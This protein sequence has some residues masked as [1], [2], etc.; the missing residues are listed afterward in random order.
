MYRRVV[1][2]LVT[3]YFATSVSAHSLGG[4]DDI[5]VLAGSLDGATL[6][7]VETA[8]RAVTMR[9]TTVDVEGHEIGSG[10]VV[11]LLPSET[12]KLRLRDH[13]ASEALGSRRIQ[14][15]VLGGEGRVDVTS[16]GALIVEPEASTSKRRAVAPHDTPTTDQLID[17]AEASGAIDAETALLYR[18]Y[19]IFG[20]A[21]LP[22]AFRGVDTPETD[23]GYMTQV[24][25]KFPT[26]SP[27]TQAIV[28]P[29]L[30]PP[31]Y[32][33]SWINVKSAAP[34]ASD[35]ILPPPC[36]LFSDNW[37][38]ID[39]QSSPVRVWYRS[40]SSLDKDTAAR[41]SV[42][43]DKIWPVEIG[44]MH[45]TGTPI[46]VPLSDATEA[47]GA[48][49]S[50]LDVYLTDVPP[51]VD[52]ETIPF[53][54]GCSP[55]PAFIEISRAGAVG[56]LI[57]EMFHAIQFSY[58]LSGCGGSDDYR[59]WVEGSAKWSEDYVESAVYPGLQSEHGAATAYLN[60]TKIPLDYH[61]GTI[62][63]H[64]Y[65]TYLLPFYVARS[66]G[67]ADFVRVAWE[68]CS[69][70]PAIEAV[71]HAVPGGLDK[72]WPEF[73]K[74]NYNQPP[75]DDYQ[76]W[77]QLDTKAR[78]EKFSNQLFQDEIEVYEMDYSLPHTTAVL[79]H[80]N[81]QNLYKPS[82]VFWNGVT[83]YFAERQLSPAIGQQY[84]N[85]TAGSDQ[86]KGARVS[87]MIR[88]GTNWRQEDWTSKP[89]AVFCRDEKADNWDEL[90]LVFS[91]SDFSDRSRK[92]V[93]PGRPPILY[94]SSVG[95]YQWKGDVSY[96]GGSSATDATVTFDRTDTTVQPLA[97]HYA[98]QGPMTWSVTAQGC[99]ASGTAS[100]GTANALTTFNF[101]PP[102]NPAHGTYAGSGISVPISVCGSSYQFPWWTMPPPPI[103][104][105]IPGARWYHVDGNGDMDDTNTMLSPA[106]WQWHLESQRQ[107]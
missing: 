8:G 21:R 6:Q 93:P 19:S 102:D 72:I 56:T 48:S 84:I 97:V 27:A 90:V 78:A 33:D 11:M 49:D 100:V 99:N 95:C 75:V 10:R 101:L 73:A 59:W 87:A 5:V 83:T 4:R 71:D 89:F 22:V 35:D 15:E 60:D 38:Y 57:H 25:A 13:F 65:G 76:K 62:A 86:I 1:L 106:L 96:N 50:R 67:S 46:G 14:I 24:R 77:D 3:A 88:T 70:E 32:K 85:D 34:H 79:Y 28:Q 40:D 63:H 66:T 98:A 26:L 2:V 36:Q 82:V 81:F 45:K 44:L 92:L 91:N 20:D 103:V 18:V 30:V 47:C 55:S 23:S 16:G 61:E 107:Q 52:G 29:F 37:A 17:K 39:A 105:G 42:H 80:F 64:A 9:V 58:P 69:R 12:R 68:N 7:F 94:V 31:A 104:P 54:L 43:A 51:G 74:H 41:L 53:D